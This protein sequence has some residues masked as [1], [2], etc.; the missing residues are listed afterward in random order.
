VGLLAWGRLVVGTYINCLDELVL[1]VID[2]LQ[3]FR[4]GTKIEGGE[5]TRDLSEIATEYQAPNSL[6]RKVIVKAS[7]SVSAMMLDSIFFE[8]FLSQF[9]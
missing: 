7:S 2:C 8:E 4:R 3:L 1:P 6:V 9:F 5:D